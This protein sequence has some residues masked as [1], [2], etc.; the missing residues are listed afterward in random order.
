MRDTTMSSSP[1]TFHHD[2]ETSFR[3]Q[4]EY[5]SPI[6]FPPDEVGRIDGPV[7]DLLDLGVSG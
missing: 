3:R 7:S 2:P 6:G 4:I 5:I 1:F